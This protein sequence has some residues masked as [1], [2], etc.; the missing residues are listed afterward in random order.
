MTEN[1]ERVNQLIREDWHIKTWEMC[2]TVGIGINTLKTV[3]D[4]LGYR[5]LCARWL[6]QMLTP[7]RKEQ[8]VQACADLLLQYETTGHFLDSIVTGHETWVHHYEPE[9]KRHSIEWWHKNSA[10]KKKLRAQA[11]AKK[12]CFP[13][14]GTREGLFLWISWN[15]GTINSACC[16]G[17]Q[18]KLKTWIARVR[19]EKK[20][21]IL[22]Q[23]NSA[24]SRTN[25]L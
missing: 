20:E 15:R 10:T 17:T 25:I 13:F 12:L 21:E 5:K 11:S 22:L 14:F 9:S 16:V 2:E 4:T 1:E 24:M 3:V 18:R 6:L 23:H 8:R 19:P 7:D